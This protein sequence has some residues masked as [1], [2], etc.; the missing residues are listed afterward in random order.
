[1]ILQAVGVSILLMGHLE[2]RTHLLQEEKWEI[3]HRGFC[4]V[5]EV[6][7]NPVLW[8]GWP[9]CR[10]VPEEA[11]YLVLTP[12]ASVTLYNGPG[13]LPTVSRAGFLQVRKV[14]AVWEQLG[15]PCCPAHLWLTI[16]AVAGQ[17]IGGHPPLRY[18]REAACERKGTEFWH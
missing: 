8:C 9:A 6:N 10:Q 5:T 14:T 18:L 3:D 12:P 17:G 1:M 15:L 11:R 4:V 2:I 13:N 16:S 7:L